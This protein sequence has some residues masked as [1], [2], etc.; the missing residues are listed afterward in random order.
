MI[1]IKAPKRVT[2]N[3]IQEF[4]L[5]FGHTFNWKKKMVPNQLIDLS[6]IEEID[7]LGLL[8]IYK[9]IDFTYA[10]YCFKK[11]ELKVDKYLL[12]TWDKY[13]FRDLIE[14]Y[15]H[16]E[17]KSDRPFKKLKIT[18]NDRFI[19]APQA[20][21]RESKFTNENIQK[22][23]IPKIESYYKKNSKKTDVIFS[24]FS[25]IILNFWEHAVL[26][27][28]SIIIADGNNDKIEIACAD[29]GNGLFSNLRGV[30]D[31]KI[32]DDAILEKSVT[33]GVTSKPN[34]FHMGYGLWIVNQL[35]TANMG[36]LHLYSEGYFYQNNYGKI[37]KGR[38]PF[39]PGTIIYVNLSLKKPK[40]LADLD[41]ISSKIKIN[42]K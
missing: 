36:K 15:I 32:K 42:F 6:E 11:P 25:E 29:T 9:Y 20:L 5:K 14:S 39:W 19:I 12:E 37:K 35:V 22:A 41:L 8:I 10:N 31:S 27:T 3:N 23:F 28:K 30:L 21:L 2:K 17:N 34:T 24:C 33:K 26:D 13:A 4:I 1:S 38:S 16:N 18:S 40:S 7:I